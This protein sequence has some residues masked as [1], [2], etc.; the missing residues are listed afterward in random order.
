MAALLSQMQFPVPINECYIFGSPRIG[1]LSSL[2]EY[3]RIF[4]TRRH[5]DI[6][7]HC[8]PHALGFENYARQFTCSGSEFDEAN[9]LELQFF[10]SWLLNLALKRFQQHHSMEHYRFETVEEA[11]RNLRNPDYWR[12]DWPDFR[13][14]L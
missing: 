3:S 9:K 14:N 13:P 1:K 12:D 6:V 11:R 2:Q 5:L 4:A 7:T 10:A 8:P